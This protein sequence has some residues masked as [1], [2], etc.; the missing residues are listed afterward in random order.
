MK[1]SMKSLGLVVGLGLVTLSFSNAFALSALPEPQ[2]TSN[3]SGMLLASRSL[4]IS[5]H[6]HR[7][8]AYDDGRLVKSG[9]ASAG[10]NYCP[11]IGRSC[12]TPRGT[13][14]VQS[15]GGSG[16]KSTRYPVG[17]GGA[18]MPYC[19]FFSKNYAVHGSYDVPKNR[20]ASHGCVRVYPSDAR[21]LNQ[22][23]LRI[24]DRVT[25]TSY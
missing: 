6:D 10:A 25:V 15:K 17:R 13:Y 22:D 9:V 19:M 23:F 4:V 20:N 21:W 11:D 16:C 7:W 18:P 14:S 3:Y 24:G 12:R 1:R 8:Y 2:S 5:P